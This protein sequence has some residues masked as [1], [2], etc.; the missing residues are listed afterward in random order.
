MDAGILGRVA[1]ITI[2]TDEENPVS[3][4]TIT[5]ESVDVAEGYRVRVKPMD[6]D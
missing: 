6:D 5:A 3:V 4:A 1:D 2:E